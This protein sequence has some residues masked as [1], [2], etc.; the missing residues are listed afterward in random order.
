MLLREVVEAPELHLRLLHGR[1][2][3]LERPV[4]WTYS[5]DLLDPSRYLDGEELVISGLVWRRSP[6]DS[7][8]FVTTIA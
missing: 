2:E 3:A 7:E 1:T 6:S 4:R 8:T 5:S